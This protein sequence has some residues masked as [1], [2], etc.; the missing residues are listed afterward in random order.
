MDKNHKPS[1][2]DDLQRLVR[3]PV[4]WTIAASC[5]FFFL[6]APVSVYWWSYAAHAT[7]GTAQWYEL[8]PGQAPRYL[9]VGVSLAFAAGCLL[10][11]FLARRKLSAWL[12]Q[13]L[14]AKNSTA[15]FFFFIVA[16]V[17]FY[18]WQYAAHTSQI[19]GY[20]LLGVGTA[21]FMV[22]CLVGFV[23]TSYGEETGT[24]GK[25]RDWVIGGLAGLTVAQ[26]SQG[27]GFFK[28]FLAKFTVDAKNDNQF[29]LVLSLAI[30]YSSL[31]FLFMF[32][33]RELVWNPRLA[34][35][36]KERG[37]LD[38]TVQA[39]A[40]IQKL[41]VQLPPSILT[42]VQD[43]SDTRVS[44]KEA[45]EL[46]NAVYNDDVNTFLK[47]A[48]EAVRNGTALGWDDVSKVAHIHYYRAYFETGD[49]HA[50]QAQKA[51]EWIAR[52][53]ALNP[54]HADLTM[55]YA[56]MLDAD[57]QRPATVAV[58]ENLAARAEAPAVTF[59]W[60]GYYLRGDLDRLDDSIRC[61]NKFLALFPG[62]ASARFNLSYAYFAKYCQEAQKKS[63][64]SHKRSEYHAKALELLAA[65]LEVDP[66]FRDKVADW[67]ENPE[68][69]YIDGDRDFRDLAPKLPP[70]SAS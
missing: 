43:V 68:L 27:G 51:L 44:S 45:E 62:D 59:E 49:N 66:G 48:E 7:Q 52:A 61:S 50:A 60:L 24:I 64:D 57:K 29:G 20:L 32:F 22:G 10:S 9:L 23:F 65:A 14:W 12:D 54:M 5:I 53:L 35:S 11:F 26:A 4:F 31:G 70:K 25:V 15:L 1:W 38:G 40:V 41:L 67:P 2:L 13:D 36:R 28:N 17:S 6:V 46:K 55:K 3:T 42:G 63:S 16:P 30:V 34:K 21:C 19:P 39:T 8:H 69:K 18:W 58:L 56:D 47:Q 37:L 33:Q